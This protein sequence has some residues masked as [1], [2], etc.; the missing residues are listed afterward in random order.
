MFSTLKNKFSLEGVGRGALLIVT[1]LISIAF[2]PGGL[3]SPLFS[4]SILLFVGV[5]VALLC[6]I[7]NAIKTNK[8]QIPAPLFWIPSFILLITYVISAFF[9]IQKNA[10]FMGYGFESGTVHSI[11]LL[12][13]FA[14]LIQVYFKTKKDLFLVLTTF[15]SSILLLILF[16]I[17]RLVG[18]D[19]F[20]SLG[21]FFI[22]A[23]SPIGRWNE[24][25]VVSALAVFL[26]LIALQVLSLPR[27]VKILVYVLMVTSFLFIVLSNFVFHFPFLT[28]AISL[29]AVISLV[30]LVFLGYFYSVGGKKDIVPGSNP[31]SRL[32]IPSLVVLIIALV[33]VVG[34]RPLND[35]LSS[36]FKVV[37]S[38][39]RPSWAATV[40]IAEKTLS[41]KLLLGS[42]PE[43]FSHE[44]ALYKPAQFNNQNLFWDVDFSLGIGFIPTA[45]ITGGLLVGSAWILMML[46]ILY[47]S[48]RV[49][50]T[51]AKDPMTLFLK[52]TLVS[53]TLY[54]LF[55]ATFYIPGSVLLALLFLFVGS[56]FSYAEK[57]IGISGK[58][59]SL[60]TS[61]NKKLVS[62]FVMISLIVLSSIW[63]IAFGKKV[64]ASLLATFAIQKASAGNV[65]GARIDLFR[66]VELDEQSLY[67]KLIAQ[68]ALAGLS[69][70]VSKTTEENI[71]QFRDPIQ[72]IVN[73]AVA[74]SE[75]AEVVE[76]TNFRNK[77][78]TGAIYESLARFGAPDL[79][80]RAIEKYDQTK[81]AA[82]TSPLPYLLEA[83]VEVNRGNLTKAK[84]YIAG[85]ISLK[86]DYIDAYLFLSDI[87][88]QQGDKKASQAI[89]ENV[90]IIDPTNVAIKYQVGL[91]KYDAKNYTAAIGDFTNAL[92]INP[93]FA[94]ARYFLALSLYRTGDTEGAIREMKKVLE[95]NPENTDVKSSIEKLEKGESLFTVPKVEEDTKK[96][97]TK[98]VDDT[99]QAE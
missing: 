46:S 16:H 60:D 86:N 28:S 29:P 38:E 82:P 69:Q 30:A 51:P 41:Q 25:A 24:L 33:L 78:A 71:S 59:I 79:Y 55:V 57:E 9:S 93:F 75:R 83:R 49:M 48:Y 80:L 23:S 5:L 65:E 27:L 67:L 54:L 37:Y 14:F 91:L 76:P 31:S 3:I 10:S 94:N 64:S 6:F 61:E 22:T 26:S 73:E 43:T 44:W 40:G 35:K 15:F 56:L 88:I 53:G 19:G 99:K 85:A 81:I 12:V 77:L 11:A 84:E 98:E 42:G 90:L 7:F 13:L 4:K 89:L 66:A 62:A 17:I 87:A 32:S 95:T 70:V 21:N 52:A 50:K 45:F 58:V 2:V 92:S 8:L 1:F 47:V 63:M 74:A 18:G 36:Y 96:A 68:N 97:G 39:G 72:M 20:L 34:G